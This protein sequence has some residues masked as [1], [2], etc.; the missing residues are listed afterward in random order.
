MP[1][2]TAPSYLAL[3][4]TGELE[5]RA[6]AAQAQLVECTLCPWRCRA[7]RLAGKLGVCLSGALARVA[8]YGPHPGEEPPLSGTRGSGTVFFSRCNLR[9]IFCQNHEVSQADA[10]RELQP[11]E[12]AQVFLNLQSQGCHNINLVSPSHVVPHILAALVIAARAGLRLPLVYNTGGYDSLEALA[13]LEDVVDIYL[14]DMKFAEPALAKQYCSPR[15]YPVV[16]QAAVREMY[17]QVGNLQLDSDGIAVRGLIVR[18]LVMPAHQA[19]TRTVAAFL[20]REISPAVTLNLM[21]QYQ[22]AHR[23]AAFPILNRRITPAELHKAQAEVA[24]AGLQN[25]TF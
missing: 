2:Q 22:P 1:P 4:Y 15:D 19:G 10:G 8:S 24:A 12:L 17:R 5:A 25:H 7:N 23:A 20:A 3:L 21:D 16:N 9:C 13:L 18:H 14:P 11:G 6:A